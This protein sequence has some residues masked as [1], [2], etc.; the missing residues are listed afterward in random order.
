MRDLINSALN[1]LHRLKEGRHTK[2]IVFS[3]VGALANP[4]LQ[5]LATPVLFKHLG[6]AEFGIWAL[7]NGIL[8]AASIASFGL[9]ESA[10]KYVAK[11]LAEGQPRAAVGVAR[12]VLTIYGV[13]GLLVPLG[14]AAAAPWISQSFFDLSGEGLKQGVTWLYIACGGLVVRFV[15]GVFEAIAR[16][17]HRYDKE[18]M[19]SMGSSLGTTVAALICVFS[20]LGLTAILICSVGILFASTIGLGVSCAALARDWK[21]VLPTLRVSDMRQVLRFSFFAWLQSLNGF[22]LHTCDR[23]LIGY[24]LGPSAVGY[25]SVCIQLVQTLH[26]VVARAFGFLFPAVV[27]A[28]AE[29]TKDELLTLF[30]RSLVAT[31]AFGI[32]GSGFLVCFSYQI[33]GMWMGADF[34]D[35]SSTTLAVLALWNMMLSTSVPQFY[36]LNA[37]GEEQINTLLGLASS[38]T[39]LCATALMLPLLGIKGAAIGR[40]CSSLVGVFG[41]RI[42]LKRLFNLP[43]CLKAT[44]ATMLAPVITGLLLFLLERMARDQQ[45]P[46]LATCVFCALVC[47]LGLFVAQRVCNVFIRA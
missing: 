46:L 40:L 4:A 13:L 44:F 1:Q 36:F 35:H 25:Y 9:G 3:A 26:S 21:I 34:A 2:N 20:G 27:K 19:F 32:I 38:L 8:S 30:R 7:I 37:A 15:Y 6:A 22:A 16:G 33:L 24:L 31:T 43:R 23:F 45:M 29:G 28:H 5:L 42:V 11:S 41:R 18:A 47:S 10:T 14:L 17:Y 39:S 12:G